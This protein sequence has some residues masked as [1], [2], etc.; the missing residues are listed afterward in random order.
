MGRVS[1]VQ[2]GTLGLIKDTPDYLLA[3]EAWTEV[4]NM[5]FIDGKAETAGA[6][7]QVLGTPS[8]A[9]YFAM[10]VR[11]TAEQL[12]WLYAGLAKIYGYDGTT[13]TDLTRVS[14]GD[15]NATA[16]REWNS[17]I[18]GGIAVLNNGVDDPQ[19]WADTSL[20]TKMADL[21][22]WPAN[23]TAKVIKALGNYL[24]A[25][26]TTESGTQFGHRVR[27]SHPAVP[28]AVPSSWDET[29][30]TKDA[31]IYDLPDSETGV[32]LDARVLNGQLFLYKGQAV[33]RMWHIG[34]QSIFAFQE[35]LTTV[36]L[37]A[38]R[39]VTT[40]PDGAR[41]FMVTT[42]DILVHNG[43]SPQSIVEKKF[44]RAL[45]RSIDTTNYINSF[46]FPNPQYNEVWFCF[47]E[48]GSEF[49]TRALTWNY[50]DNSLGFVDVDFQAASSGAVE[51]A[52][53]DIWD[54][55]EDTTWDEDTEV[56]SE[57]QAKRTVVVS[58]VATK[59]LQL[60]VGTTND[61]VDIART[62]QRTGLS[63]TGDNNRAR[64]IAD[65]S[66]RKMVNR[67]WIR[68]TGDTFSVKLGAYDDIEEAPVW[69]EAQEFTPGVDRYVDIIVEGVFYAIEFF[70]TGS[71]NWQVEGWRLEVDVTG[72]F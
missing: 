68:A 19:Y 38:T 5:R 43:A 9:P 30:P 7:K 20:G 25:I 52:I 50:Q 6:R 47:P 23:T 10:P 58:P 45:F 32:L 35:F 64:P 63:Y 39:C 29:D 26:N 69:S 33:W 55:G 51:S 3:P 60:D 21:A 12:F 18:L 31:G 56:W 54:D 42:D 48:S 14:G 36:G 49:P 8:V 17:T 61:G 22:N 4:R 67:I 65:D 70:S 16:A 2:V 62:L 66:L 24:V 46:V 53:D 37:L 57:V 34:G 40:V 15:Y 59:L 27:W 11:G 1:A 72:E 44:R 13:H 71:V 41:H 28:G